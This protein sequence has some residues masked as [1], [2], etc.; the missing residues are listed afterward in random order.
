M[1]LQVLE[2]RLHKAVSSKEFQ[3]VRP[4][5]DELEKLWNF[6]HAPVQEARAHHQEDCHAFPAASL[7]DAKAHEDIDDT[8]ADMLQMGAEADDPSEVVSAPAHSQASQ[9]SAGQR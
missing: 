8:L 4:L 5:V 6:L 2:D 3:L 9:V 7:Q 1:D